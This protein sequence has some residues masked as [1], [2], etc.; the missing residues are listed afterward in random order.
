[1]I[2]LDN[3]ATTF[4]KPPQVLRAVNEA[5][6]R[7]GANPGRSGHC[8]SLKTAE[9]IYACREKA[10][11]FFGLA[12][13]QGVV[14]TAN[15]TTALNMV[16]RGV[17]GDSGRVLISDIEH[18]AVWRT[19]NALPYG[20]R[21][22]M[23]AWSPDDDE[24]VENFRRAITRDTRLIVCTHAS[25]VFGVVMPIRRLARLAHEHGILICVDAAQSGGI[26]PINMEQDDVDFLCVAPHKGL[27]APMGTGMLLCRTRRLLTPLICGGTGSGSLSFEQPSELPERLESGTVNVAGICGIAAGLDFLR[28]RGRE[29]VYIHETALLQYAYDSLHACE[30]V[31]LYT[32]RPSVGRTVPV[33]SVNIDGESSEEVA[34]RLNK[35]GVAVRAGL[36]CAPLAH[37]RFDTI[38][39]GTVRIAP[40]AFTTMGEMEKV[41]KLFSHFSQ[42]K[43][44]T[45]KNML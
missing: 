10:A 27:Y 34:E 31:K 8:M 29:R 13:A 36:H 32:C 7:Y 21:Y 33:M 41:C 25:N 45:T 22:D 18:N 17:V 19:V 2:Y 20:K 23:A 12:D 35:Y 6:M 24:I 1:M 4:P 5:I 14:F 43:L 9:M 11:D 37:R 15:C 40:S 44:H 28:M 3:A 16:I 39:Q 42:N 26:L 38:P 30:G